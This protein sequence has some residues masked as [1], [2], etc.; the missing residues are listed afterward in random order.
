MAQT[1]TQPA[2]RAA[3]AGAAAAGA[4][5]QPGTARLLC[6]FAP[7]AAE[8]AASQGCASLAPWPTDAFPVGG[9]VLS[10]LTALKV[11]RRIN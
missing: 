4:A 10:C 2:G 8:C 6:E 7:A 1:L 3:A 9:S 11:I 5:A